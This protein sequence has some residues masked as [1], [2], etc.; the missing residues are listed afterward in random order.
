MLHRVLRDGH[1]DV[2]VVECVDEPA[3]GFLDRLV[4]ENGGRG[5]EQPE[6]D[7][8]GPV[9]FHQSGLVLCQR[10][11]DNLYYPRHPSMLNRAD[12]L[13][14]GSVSVELATRGSSWRRVA[15]AA[16]LVLSD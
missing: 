4:P 7:Q 10:V 9:P 6:R 5:G 16:L 11:A 1:V 12:A 14:D 2:G 15:R 8:D 3:A 13:P